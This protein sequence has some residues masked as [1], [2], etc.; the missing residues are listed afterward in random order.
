MM[1]CPQTPP[2]PSTGEIKDNNQLA[3]RAAKAHNNNGWCNGNG[4]GWYDGNM[5]AT[6][7]EGAMAMEGT[8]A[9]DGMTVTA[10]AMVVMGGA[11]AMVMEGTRAMQ[12]QW[13]QWTAQQRR[14]WT[15]LWQPNGGDSDGR[16]DG[17]GQ[18]RSNNSRLRARI[19]A[20]HRRD[21]KG[22]TAMQPAGSSNKIT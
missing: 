22:M 21:E 1:R 14:Q 10:T 16:D 11:T 18:Q 20:R 2:P 17:N 9:V 7:M 8:T 6:P 4:N 15:A 12:R 19:D 3:T 5:M 13:W